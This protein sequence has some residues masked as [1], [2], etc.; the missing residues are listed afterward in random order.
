MTLR[1]VPRP[2]LGESGPAI[3]RQPVAAANPCRVAGAPDAAGKAGAAWADDPAS[4][5]L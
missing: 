3:F 4:F 2:A 1:D 5:A